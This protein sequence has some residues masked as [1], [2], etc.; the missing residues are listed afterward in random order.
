[1]CLN[2]AQGG[3]VYKLWQSYVPVLSVLTFLG[4]RAH[5]VLVV[6]L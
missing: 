5:V 6:T 2:Q 4:E 1:M 3:V